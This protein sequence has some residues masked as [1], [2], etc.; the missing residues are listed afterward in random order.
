VTKPLVSVIVPAYN[1]ERYLAAALDSIFAQT[2]RPVEVIVIDDGSTDR[3]AQII[4]GY[5]DRVVSLRQDNSGPAAARNTG[6]D[7]ARGEFI[8]FLD[9]DDLY[10]PEKLARQMA[11]FD[12]H[13]AMEMSICAVENFWDGDPAEEAS[14]LRKRELRKVFIGVVVQAVLVRRSVFDKV[15]RFKADLRFCEDTDWYLRTGEAKVFGE[16]LHE[17]LVYRR[18]H[19]GNMTREFPPIMRDR[20]VDVYKASIDRLREKRDAAARV[21]RNRS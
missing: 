10:H 15:G 6:L 11:L 16:W 17:T 21:D 8:S 9:A 14:Q 19:E 18:V 13:P 1:C 7:H 5:G 2:Y 20:L 12:R 4:A 3:T